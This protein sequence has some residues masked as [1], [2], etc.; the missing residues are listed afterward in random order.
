MKASL[1]VWIL[2]LL[3][4]GPLTSV[5]GTKGQLPILKVR[6]TKQQTDSSCGLA[7]L[8]SIMDYWG[9]SNDPTRLLRRHPSR[10]SNGYS[11]GE[12]KRIALE[13][14]LKAF[15]IRGSYDFLKKQLA[16]ERPVL[17]ALEVPYN[18]YTVQKA[19]KVSFLGRVFG[20]G[21]RTQTFSH[22]M[23]VRGFDQEEVKVMDPM[24][25]LKSIP[26]QGFLKMWGEMGKPLLL[27]SR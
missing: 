10:S 11:L 13:K 2:I 27:V 26:R 25:G 20:L 14:G 8:S 6:Y 4:F 24:Y 17:V 5:W 1:L 23:V 19:E 16:K 12:L 9:V 7:G 22:F 15:T 18:L 3:W 21:G